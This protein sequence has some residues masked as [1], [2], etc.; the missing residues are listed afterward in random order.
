MFN[1]ILLTLPRTTSGGGGKS[2]GDQVLE[3]AGDILGKLPPNF[4]MEKIIAK[5]PVLYNESMNTVL[6]QVRTNYL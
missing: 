5:Y 1:S 4:D 6:R 2:A 3:L